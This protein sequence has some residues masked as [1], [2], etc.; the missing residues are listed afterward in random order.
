MYGELH[1]YLILHKQ[2]NV[3]GIG[4]FQVERKP[5]DV[6]VAGKMI[7]PPAYTIA[8]H[9]S[10]ATPS[11]KIF[12]WLAA[13]LNI[14]E[15]DALARFNDFAFDVRNKIMAGEKL[16]W[17][18]IGILSK[19]MAGEIRFEASLKG[20]SIGEP[21][22][23]NK[24]IRDDAEHRIMVGEQEKT[25]TEMLEWLNPVQR[26]RSYWWVLSLLIGLL[27]IAFI[28]WHFYSKGL[29]TSAAANQQKLDP[30]KETSTYKIAP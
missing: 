25:S 5:A 24:V 4:T 23:A 12:T 13:E 15:Y 27:A 18:G 1:Q 9:H 29:V 16:L 3:P 10:N 20:I 8:L 7:Y 2:L 17:N 28:T 22:A 26:K 14:S 21:V 6:D 11:K 30:Q 19:G